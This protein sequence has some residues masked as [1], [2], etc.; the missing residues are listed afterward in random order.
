MKINNSKKGLSKRLPSFSIIFSG[1]LFLHTSQGKNLL[2]KQ[3]KKYSIKTCWLMYVLQCLFFHSRML[4]RT[5]LRFIR[6]S[7]LPVIIFLPSTFLTLVPIKLK[8]FISFS[9]TSSG[10]SIPTALEAISP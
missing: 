2:K 8:S 5:F 1:F 9:S 3:S 7:D 6:K 10:I 4:F